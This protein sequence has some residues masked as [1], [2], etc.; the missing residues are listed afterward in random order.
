MPVMD[1]N[2]NIGA[3]KLIWTKRA[4]ERY[5]NGKETPSHTISAPGIEECY[6]GFVK[7]MRPGTPWIIV[8][9][10]RVVVAAGTA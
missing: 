10:D 8:A 9:P 1:V 7:Q 6:E 5:V 4:I 2:G 3:R